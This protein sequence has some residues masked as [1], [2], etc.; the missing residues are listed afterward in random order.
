MDHE[1][2]LESTASRL[3][4]FLTTKTVVGEPIVIGNVTLLPVQVASFGFGSGGGEGK[5]EKD[6][7]TAGGAGGGASLRP[8]A[9]VAV[10]ND[11]VQVFTLGK[12]DTL[13][14]LANLIP[15]YIS[16]IRQGKGRKGKSVEAEE[17][18]K[19]RD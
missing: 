4:K 2:M 16:K 7:G 14:Q 12:K 1:N 5:G 18:A 15:D 8:I 19:D 13:G 9:I 10:V 17:P 6:A 3:E 11:D